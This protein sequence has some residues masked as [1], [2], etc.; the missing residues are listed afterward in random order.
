MRGADRSVFAMQNFGIL[1]IE[2]APP[3]SMRALGQVYVLPVKGM[4]KCVKATQRDELRAVENGV[5]SDRVIRLTKS[6]H[7]W[8][9]VPWIVQYFCEAGLPYQAL[10]SFPRAAVL[11]GRAQGDRENIV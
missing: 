6:F 9:L 4:E 2:H 10:R 11:V 5:T 3:A 7:E 1:S 8:A